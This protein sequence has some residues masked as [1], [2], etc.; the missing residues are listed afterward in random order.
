MLLEDWATRADATVLKLYQALMEI[1]RE[2]AARELEP[3][4]APS[5]TV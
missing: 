2:D 4:L 1:G 3:F 5:S